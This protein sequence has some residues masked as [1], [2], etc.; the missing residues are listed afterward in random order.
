MTQSASRIGGT[1][2][3]TLRG[4]N[5]A[6]TLVGGDGDDVLKGR[7]GDDTLAGGAGD[8]RLGGGKGDDMLTGGAGD[9]TLTGGRGADTFVF[10]VGDGTD[11]VTDFQAGDRIRLDGVTGGFAALRIEQDGADAVIRYGDGTDT[12]TLSGVSADSLSAIYP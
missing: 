5:G 3:D 9:D 7:K 6:D 11:T 10:V 2:D 1:G 12:I 8:D 4:G